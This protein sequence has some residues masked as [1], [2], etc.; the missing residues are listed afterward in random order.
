MSAS[1][2]SVPEGYA[3]EVN[4]Q[5]RTCLVKRR[6]HLFGEAGRIGVLAAGTADIGVAEEIDNGFGAGVFASLIARQSCRG[7]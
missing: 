6:G 7:N 5:A 4:R 1:E 2:S 3:L